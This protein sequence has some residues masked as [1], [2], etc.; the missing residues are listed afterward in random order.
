MHSENTA[1][2]IKRFY[3]R[4]Y[5][6]FRTKMKWWYRVGSRPAYTTCRVSNL[7]HGPRV[8]CAVSLIVFSLSHLLLHSLFE[9]ARK[10][11][12]RSPRGA[13]CDNF[14]N[15]VLRPEQTG[16]RRRIR[17]YVFFLARVHKRYIIRASCR[18]SVPGPGSGI[19]YTFNESLCVCVR[20]FLTRHTV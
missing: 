7:S 15:V 13:S 14:R 8:F 2:I 11:P 4:I 5:V 16:R 12:K 10:I 17:S 3:Y 9:L 19:A 1:S 6:H 18:V 20:A